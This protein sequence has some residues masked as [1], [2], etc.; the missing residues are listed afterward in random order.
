LSSATSSGLKTS[1]RIIYPRRS[2]RYLSSSVITYSVF[3]L[4]CRA[5]CGNNSS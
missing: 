4:R 2:K 3:Q 5:Y 1:S